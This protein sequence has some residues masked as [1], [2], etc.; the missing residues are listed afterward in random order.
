MA[1]SLFSAKTH[2]LVNAFKR[3]DLPA[4]VY[5][6]I[7]ITGSHFFCLLCL[8]RS[9]IFSNSFNFSL[10]FICL[11]FRCLFILSV[12]VSPSHL[13]A[14]DH[15]HEFHPCLLNSIH[16]PKILGHMCLIAANSICNFASTLSAC[17]SKIFKIKSILSRALI[18]DFNQYFSL[19]R[20]KYSFI[21]K[22]CP[23]FKTFHIIKRFAH[24]LI[25]S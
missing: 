9:L 21:S 1:K 13:V 22:I 24:V 16:I 4:F 3:E 8:C 14:Q 20:R 10:I 12:L 11:S 19:S 18:G 6:T 5:H 17:L 23:G 7:H 15:H 2:F 25:I